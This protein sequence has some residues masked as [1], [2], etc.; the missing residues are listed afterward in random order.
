[1]AALAGGGDEGSVAGHILKHS[2]YHRLS[3]VLWGAIVISIV[4]LAVY[5]SLGRMLS[6][7]S[8]S[9]Q[10]Q[11]LQQLN[12]RVPFTV[13]AHRV[14]AQWHSF[15]P[16]LVLEDLR[17]TMPGEVGNTLEL[18]EGR[19]A[20]DVAASL[21]SNAPQVT[22]LQL[23]GLNL[24]GELDEQG[25]LRV[26]GFRAGDSP[27]GDWLESLLLN[28]E[29]VALGATHLELLLP[30]G[31][32]RGFD[33]DIVLSREGSRRHLEGRLESSRGMN[34][35]VLGEGVG[36]PFEPQSFTGQ[37]YLDID[38]DDLGAINDLLPASLR[39]V[40][41]DG[42]LGMQLWSS[43]DLGE[44]ATSLRLAMEDVSLLAQDA[45][46][47]LALD[48]IAF[49]A[50]L[51][52]RQGGWGLSVAALELL[53]DEAQLRVPRMQLDIRGETVD[54]WAVEF[55]L[56]PLGSL[57]AG[58]DALP[59][60]AVDLL[61]VL[62][63]RGSLPAVDISIADITAP[64]AGWQL[65]ATF[66]QLAVDPWH[67]APGVSGARGY[68]ELAPGSGFVQLDSQQFSMTFPTIYEAPLRYDSF[69]GTIHIDWN[70]EAVTLSSGLV[71]AHGPEGQVPVLFG[72]D[73][74]LAPSEVGLE[75]DLLVGLNDTHPVQRG[76][77]IP[78]ILNPDLRS[79]LEGSI[80]DG[81]IEEGGF[82]WRGSLTAAS[83]ALHTVQLFFKVRDM[84][85]SYHP[86]WPALA[87][88]EG[89]VLIDDSNVSVWAE[90]ASL[91][92]SAV[93]DLSVE[94]WV[95]QAA[96]LWLA[97]DGSVAGPA[98]DG[99]AVVN[100]SP[101]G[102]LAGGV[103][104]EWQLS[105]DLATDIDLLLN[106]SDSA[107]APVVEVSARFEGV[108]LDI[109]PGHLPVRDIGGVLVYDSATGFSSRGL[110]G[111]LWGRPLE[112]TIS[113]REGD[114]AEGAAVIMELSSVVD[115]SDVGQWLALDELGFA[116]GEAQVRARLVT[117]SGGEEKPLVLAIDSFLEGVTLDLPEPWDKPADTA[118]RLH[119]DLSSRGDSLLLGIALAGGLT[120]RLELLDGRL[121]SAALAL[122]GQPGALEPGVVRI[123]G[124]TAYADTSQWQRF[125]SDYLLAA[126]ALPEAEGAGD[127]RR[128]EIAQP[129]RGF[130]L[131]VAIDSL[132]VDRMVAYGQDLGETVF[133]LAGEDGQ[134]QLA[135]EADWVRGELR[136]VA[137]DEFRLDMEYLDLSGLDSTEPAPA[138][139]A[140]I[141][142]VPRIT[143]TID[144]LW[145]G[146]LLL[147]ELAFDLRSEGA[148]L[149]AQN[150]RG[151]IAA[152]ELRAEDPGRLVWRQGPDSRSS[153]EAD[154][155]FQDLGQ[156]LAGFGYQKAIETEEGSF[157]LALEW[158]GGPRDF[159][160]AQSE[161]SLRV[162][163]GKGHF[164]EAPGGASGALRVV[165]I[166]NLAEIVQRL[167]LSHM[168]ESGIPFDEVEGELLL[169]GGSIEVARMDVDG[170]ASSFRFS[171]VS[172]VKSRTLD[173]E[174]V[175]ILPV[176]DN[177][178]WVAALT[179][180]LPVAA[181]VFLLSKV[182][183][184]PLNRLTSAVYTTTGTWDDPRVEF[185]RVFDDASSAG[186]GAA[187]ANGA[188]PV[189][190]SPAPL[191]AQAE[192]P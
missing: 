28:V 32:V 118:R 88:V 155:F 82:L 39:G 164:P 83:E 160:L 17:I 113:Q 97:V 43:W 26:R 73:I 62:Q 29:Q 144:E 171:G 42:G 122:D 189:A 158:P 75:M 52:D 14:S 78:V 30:D 159:A 188:T 114:G 10:P 98:A 70:E 150:I 151:K 152:L 7:L 71:L 16:V 181:G 11:I 3:G 47:Q 80:G 49:D 60:A 169:H 186:T 87:D 175:V 8:V 140:Q 101:L 138:G 108:A 2:I 137:G 145:R 154:L 65:R 110:G 111:Q 168:F 179:A 6:S 86:D 69:Y 156:T 162:D 54:L 183:E 100:T 142:E 55:P 57:L 40:R 112:A 126:P 133:S 132:R 184:T 56:A 37:L 187:V 136:Y 90:S 20:L 102:A 18:S 135:A 153:L 119:L 149:H 9:F 128:E 178:P 25:K 19:I 106:L 58:I 147:G 64:L 124:R 22:Q 24:A 44:S 120:A 12:S 59:P 130:A 89:T 105:G 163:I 99:L 116:R 173:G 68:V 33:L 51:A 176:A 134:W 76:K 121:R 77:Y 172:D 27:L 95:D 4:L 91:L 96:Q 174:L 166:L 48:R 31:E 177:L 85:L 180:G 129:D 21:L 35:F 109:L 53:R 165:S 170:G 84:A 157:Q 123:A 161:G 127:P 15:N 63:P 92:D 125:M 115:V 13:E 190:E 36:N 34:M 103:F 143:V 146:D 117:G 141:I 41:I 1:M 23:E 61:R 104:G 139:E 5:V 74:P 38:T 182:F 72:L 46:W 148:D 192:S 66:D 185:D 191:P 94:V 67:G 81:L 107:V 167:S 79:W 50:S 45:S 93:S 131:A